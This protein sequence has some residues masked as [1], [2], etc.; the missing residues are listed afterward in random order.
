M[1]RV[2]V[3]TTSYPRWHGDFAGSFVEDAVRKL[4]AAGDE[5]EVVAAGPACES[6]GDVDDEIAHQ[7]V[8]RIAL[9][10]CAH[11]RAGTPGLFYGSGAPEALEQ[12]GPAVWL[13]AGAFWA[14]FCDV[15]RGSAHRWTRI[16]AH[17]LVPCGLAARA[18]APQLPIEIHAHSGDVALLERLPGGG[19][20]AR[21]IVGHEA[22]GPTVIFASSNLQDRFARLVGRSVGQDRSVEVR[23]ASDPGDAPRD[24]GARARA[25]EVLGLGRGGRTVLSVGRLVPIKGYD[26]LVRAFAEASFRAAA[27][28]PLGPVADADASRPTLVI[29]GDGPERP[30]LERLAAQLAVDLRLPGF[31]PRQEVAT[32]MAGADLY[33]QPSRPLRSGRTEGLP[34]ATLEALAAGLP[35]LASATGGLAE[36][37]YGP[38]RLRLVPPGDPMALAAC[39]EQ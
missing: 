34:V 17:W 37:P 25:R 28:R 14:R 24:P 9:P 23:G 6:A 27:T 1:S 36:L 39:L 30:R 38:P 19:A 2:G 21:F 12:G 18:V 10:S 3:L 35:V 15:I 8:R 33:V 20:L 4:R 16:Q 11:Q 32:W 22:P 31:V 29:V 13:E 7:G 5:V 26:V